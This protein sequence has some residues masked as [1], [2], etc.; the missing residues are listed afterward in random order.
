MYNFLTY[1]VTTWKQE[2]L[3]HQKEMFVLRWSCEF[4]ERQQDTLNILR[5]RYH[6]RIWGDL[7]DKQKWEKEC[8]KK[9]KLFY[10]S[11]GSHFLR[12]LFLIRDDIIHPG[13]IIFKNSPIEAEKLYFGIFC[14]IS[15]TIH[16]LY[17]IWF[18][19]ILLIPLVHLSVSLH[20]IF[21]ITP[22]NIA[23]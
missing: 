9:E 8:L 19:S 10:C 16:I 4:I 23:I 14:N 3:V 21:V 13:F 22:G 17:G 5:P 2:M 12:P 18:F 6:G 11:R 1:S 20:R 15:F 7:S